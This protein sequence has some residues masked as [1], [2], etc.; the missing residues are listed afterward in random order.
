MNR[1]NLLSKLCLCVLLLFFAA[2]CSHEDNMPDLEDKYLAL[3]NGDTMHYTEIGNENG[4]PLLFVHGFP[5]SAFLYRHVMEELCGSPA[6]P[7][8]CIAMTHIGFG[9]SSCPG[10]ASIISPLYEVDRLEEF[11]DIMGLECFAA[12]VH[13]WGGP[14]GTAASLRHAEKMTHLIILNTLLT[15]PDSGVLFTMMDTF[16]D[17]FSKPR[18]AVEACYP[19]AISLTMQALTTTWLSDN[20][21][22]QYWKPFDGDDG[23]CKVYAG[24]NLFSKGHQDAKLFDEIA[25]NIVKKWHDKPAVFIWGADDPILGPNSKVGKKEHKEMEELLPQAKTHII[26]G[27]SH[28]LQEDRPVE[29]AE[30]IRGFL[31]Q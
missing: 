9:K 13:D 19:T 22:E 2:A 7:F 30:K 16:K 1:F 28:F 6:T 24:I 26:S 12:I 14:I 27:A 21:R 31:K 11:I 20:E 4:K 3:P 8:R 17:F 10:D 5:A 15:L 23:A 25:Q 29:I 18:P